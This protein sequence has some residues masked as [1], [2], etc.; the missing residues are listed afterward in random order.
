MKKLLGAYRQNGEEHLILQEN[1]KVF[2]QEGNASEFENSVLLESRNEYVKDVLSKEEISGNDIF[3]F[4]YGPVTSGIGEAGI[5][6]LYTYGERILSVKIDTSYKRRGLDERMINSDINDA[7]K[8]SEE[9]CGNF[10]I[11]HSTAFSRAVENALKIKV[12]RDV[13]LLR[14]IALEL[15]RIYN[16]L[17][18]ISRLAQAAS[19]QVLASH[20][21]GLFED[22][23]VTNKI[24]SDSRYLMNFN[25]I[26]DVLKIPSRKELKDVSDR[27]KKIENI[28]S[29][30]YENSMSSGNYID[31]LHLTAT[32]D[33]KEAELIGLTGPSLRACGV[34]E[35]LRAYDEMYPEIEI[36]SDE[37]G[38][39]LSRM[40]VRAGEIFESLKFVRKTID[41]LNLADETTS[42]NSI[43][44]GEGI[45]WCESPSGTIVYHVEIENSKIK[46]VYVSTP[47]VFGMSAIAHSIVGNI[48]TDFPFVVESFGVNFSDAAR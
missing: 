26:G 43:G 29:K 19:Q 5:F 42:P 18:V 6:H 8:L 32:L 31:R 30:L 27:V 37:E 39:S 13:E 47:S 15:E 33:A 38:D 34:K 16:H 28:F 4:R 23:L 10:A 17:Y 25:A 35:D 9:I 46:D 2:V 1:G 22:S 45:G 21:M 11:S 20:L 48:F 41:D 3:D 14:S 40:E 7:L 24:F 44:S 12:T 36:T